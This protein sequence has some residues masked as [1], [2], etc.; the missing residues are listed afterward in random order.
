MNRSNYLFCCSVSAIIRTFSQFSADV[1]DWISCQF[2]LES[3]FGESALAHANNNF[4]GMKNP[5]VRISTAVLA[6]DS[7]VAWAQYAD[8]LACCIDYLLCIQYHKPI[9]RDYDS[10]EHYA[11]FISKFYCPEKGYIERVNLIYSQ[12]KEFKNE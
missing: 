1:A 9:T 10:I 7:N 3:S 12:F 5:L 2:A 8:L 6:G 11:S 4:C